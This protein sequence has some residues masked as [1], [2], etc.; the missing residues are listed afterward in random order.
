MK[1][2]KYKIDTKV[3]LLSSVNNKIY[4][5]NLKEEITKLK[6]LENTMKVYCCFRKNVKQ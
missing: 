1:I 5:K 2:K 6:A 4:L 3:Y